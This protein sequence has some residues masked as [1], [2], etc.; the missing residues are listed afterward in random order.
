MA[1]SIILASESPRRYE[2]LKLIGLDF[3]VIPS[4]VTEDLISS[5]KDPEQYV[6][7]MAEKKA[8]AIGKKNP[9]SWTIGADTIVYIDE[10]ILGK[11]KDKNEAREMLKRLNGREHY[12]FTG[13]FVCNIKKG[14]EG[15]KVVKTTVK[16]RELSSSEIEWYVNSSEPY[17]KAGAYA[18]QGIGSI[19]IEYINGSY[20][21]VIGL[22]LCELFQL[23]E[24]LGAIKVSQS[25]IEII[26]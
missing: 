17:D 13:L 2:L 24:K 8:L 10:M 22:P 6:I 16:M 7:Q 9:D 1:S 4:N 3:N 14:K 26:S 12:V 20:T 11:P 5:I 19:M 21:N 23:L 25:G 18:A 15:R